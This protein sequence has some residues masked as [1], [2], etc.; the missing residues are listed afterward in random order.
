[1]TQSL[2]IHTEQINSL[3][4]L[5]GIMEEM[6]IRQLIDQHV[7]PHGAWQGA[8][9][10]TLV[11]I[12]LSHLLLERD[13][14]LVVVRDW[15]A[16]RAQTL[17]S[18]LEL[19]LRDTDCSD[20]RL[21]NVLTML[22][23]TE[24][25]AS[26]DAALLQ[27]WIRVYQLPTET[28]RLDSTSV[29]V[30]HDAAEPDSLLQFGHSKDHRPDL[31]QF[32]AMLASLDPCGLPLACLPVSGQRADDG[33]YVPAYDAAV[34]VAGTPAVLVVGDSK[35][36]AL[37]TR[38][39]IGAHGSCYLC[40][41][42]PPSATD[43]IAS[44]IEAALARAEQWQTVDVLDQRTGELVPVAVVD[45][46]TREQCWVD[47]AT[48]R[49]HTWSERVLLVR[50][51]QQQ[52]GLRRRR[53]QAL[54]RLTT[55]LEALR[56]PPK[57]GRKRYT[58]RAELDG[59]VTD[60]IAAAGLSGVVHADLAEV[61]LP[62]GTS[63]WTVGRIWVELA[64]WEA[65]V[66]RLGWQVY[67]SNTTPAQY[68]SETLV[69]TYRQQ[70]VQERGFARL[71]TRNL[72][73]RPVYL[74]DEQRIKGLLWLLCL[75][76]RVLVL[77]EQRLRTA[78]EERQ[79]GLVGLNPASRKQATQRPTTERVLAVFRNI[80]LTTI[81]GAE[82]MQRHVSPLTRTQQHILDLLKLP[83]DLYDRLTEP[84][85]NSAHHLPES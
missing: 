31:R 79:E 70:P 75:A 37:G 7:T 69:A 45:A 82:V 50:S 29:S 72:Q 71:K 39:Y 21:A 61:A 78:L 44:W 59:V 14:R 20:D 68:P 36:G 76:L 56:Q 3:P 12:W 49:A 62:Q 26:L 8:S 52:D 66:A 74:R 30:Y 28:V 17:T 43:E 47:P 40:A 55:R 63:A 64:A 80:T 73:I 54:A 65:L 58:S 34:K 67:V 33:L 24:T 27:R 38:G 10:G 85:L 51:K 18:L 25:Q 11:T 41:Y 16:E 19:T 53:E 57:Q 1:M 32:K 48:K 2:T 13:H 5:I 42:R 22:G 35:M 6:G 77:T 9:V 81:D 60:L 4:L 15:A 84:I 23:D 46:W 83:P